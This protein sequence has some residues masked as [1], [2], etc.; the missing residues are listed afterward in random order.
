[1][2][3]ALR[4]QLTLGQYAFGLAVV[5]LPALAI[6]W[7]GH[8]VAGAIVFAL[9]ALAVFA[10]V[11]LLL[12]RP[13]ARRDLAAGE[14][15]RERGRVT[16]HQYDDSPDDIVTPA[17]SKLQVDAD[18]VGVLKRHGDQPVE[19]DYAP[20]SEILLELRGQDGTVL[21]RHRKLR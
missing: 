2:A 17:G 11:Y 12:I 6:G 5:V 15:A 1:M 19:V 14:F 16:L 10:V 7:F 20:H 8:A 21:Y 4:G 3:A 9:G 18:V 13:Q